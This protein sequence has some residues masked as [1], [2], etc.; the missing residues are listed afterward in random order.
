M[1]VFAA[2][3]IAVARR[4]WVLTLLCLLL[5]AVPAI[6]LIVGWFV[7]AFPALGIGT[8]LAAP[9]CGFVGVMLGN[10]LAPLIQCAAV[11]IVPGYG[12][13]LLR[14][15]SMLGVLAWLPIPLSFAIGDIDLSLAPWL[16]WVPLWAYGAIGAGFLLGVNASGMA[17]YKGREFWRR[18]LLGL[19]PML[20]VASFANV[21]VR[22]LLNAPIFQQLPG[23]TP[24][25]VMCLLLGPLSWPALLA[26]K[27][28]VRQ[29]E[30]AE[31]TPKPRDLQ[32]YYQRGG[33]AF[34][35]WYLSKL[36][37]RW[38]SKGR[39]RPELLV[40]SP[41]LLSCWTMSGFVL[42]FPFL[43]LIFP[44]LAGAPGGSLSLASVDMKMST[45]LLVFPLM[46]LMSNALDGPRMGRILLLPG[47]CKREALAP[48]LFGRLLLLWMI[49]AFITLLP[50][51]G[52]AIW[53]GVSSVT[54][55][56]YAALAVLLVSFAATLVFWRTPSRKQ[57]KTIDLAGAAVWFVLM[58]IT[59][60][61]GPL[62]FSQF[63]PSICAGVIG[64]LFAA[65]L[66]LYALARRRWQTMEY[67]A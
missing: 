20:A 38:H 12:K 8:M 7:P 65:P 5:V 41:F 57:W 45:M 11:Q 29:K 35:S 3:L 36:V 58:G 18:Y 49:G 24:L 22:E 60:L 37:A 67:G 50:A 15:A 62:F 31:G 54:L 46:P 28:T 40:F 19:L 55:A 56:L 25:A 9:A 10:V 2:I 16:R 26:R 4:S 23:F 64:L 27:V 47:V 66:T 13:R 14:V 59:P 53:F 63:A 52:W 43:M 6:S 17:A 1:K 42:V 48:W 44:L 33:S 51:L 32:T 39:V 61:L 30:Q 34:D 21:T